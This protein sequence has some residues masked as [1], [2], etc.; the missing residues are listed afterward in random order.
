MSQYGNTKTHF[1]PTAHGVTQEGAMLPIAIPAK[2]TLD[3]L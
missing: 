2:I 1:R 3:H